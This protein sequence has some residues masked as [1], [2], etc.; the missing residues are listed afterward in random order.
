MDVKSNR[1]I[2][3]TWNA[4]RTCFGPCKRMKNTCPWQVFFILLMV[5]VMDE[6]QCK[7]CQRSKRMV[8][9]TESVIFCNCKYSPSP[10][11]KCLIR[12]ILVTVNQ[13]TQAIH[14]YVDL[15]ITVIDDDR[16]PNVRRRDR[17]TNGS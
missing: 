9:R 13:I 4:L 15:A 17:R 8:S 14:E 6:D 5:D 11:R 10:K 1:W 7:Y 12:T 3:W 2:L 16:G